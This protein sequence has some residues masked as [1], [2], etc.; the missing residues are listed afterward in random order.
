MPFNDLL[1]ERE[2]RDLRAQKI[3]ILTGGLL[4]TAFAAG[5]VVLHNTPPG[6]AILTGIVGG[7]FMIVVIQHFVRQLEK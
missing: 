7:C 6:Y 3:A 1:R 4:G 2:R 5:E